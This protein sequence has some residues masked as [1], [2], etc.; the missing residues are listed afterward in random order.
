MGGRGFEGGVG[1]VR[2][3][4]VGELIMGGRRDGV[5]LGLVVRLRWEGSA[6]VFRPGHRLVGRPCGLLVTG[7]VDL[8][9]VLRRNR[10]LRA[11]CRVL[12]RE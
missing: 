5:G 4:L 3:D 6:R 10:P 12:V 1:L 7:M 8:A 11:V 9:R 2:G